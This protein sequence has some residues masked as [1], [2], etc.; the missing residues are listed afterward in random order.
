MCCRSKGARVIMERDQSEPQLAKVDR[1]PS[2]TRSSVAFLLCVALIC[3]CFFRANAARADAPKITLIFEIDHGQPF[4]PI[5]SGDK[6]AQD[7]MVAD[8]QALSSKYTV[9]VKLTGA[10][11]DKAVRDAALQFLASHHIHFIID[12]YASDTLTTVNGNSPFD[13]SHGVGLSVD[14]MQKLKDE[15]GEWFAGVRIFE[16]YSI[17]FA[18][19]MRQ[20]RGKVQ[21]ARRF[22]DRLPGDGFFQPQILKQWIDFAARNH[23]RVFFM[24]WYWLFDHPVTPNNA[25]LDQPGNEAVLARLIEDHP[26]VVTPMYDNNEPNGGSRRVYDSW[27]PTF[28]ALVTHGAAGFGLSDQAWLCNRGVMN[29]PVQDLI[30]WARNA[31]DNGASALE[32]EPYWYWWTLPRGPAK[33]DYKEGITNDNRGEPRP[34]LQQLAKALGV[35]L[36]EP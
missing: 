8:L 30:D 3:S 31:L 33:N 16:T 28:R 9:Y 7:R 17:N 5:E 22:V 35:T 23:M 20:H 15:Y 32:F 36:P 19:F 27:T 2:A 4:G 29:C 26:N 1:I 25:E 34:A 6:V 13:V 10:E 21:W 12:A 14:E 24:D 11:T 18:I